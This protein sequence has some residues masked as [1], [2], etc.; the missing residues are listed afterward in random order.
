[1]VEVTYHCPYCGAVTGIEREGYLADR[2][3]TKEPLDGWTY[4]DTT[5]DYEDAD[6][7]ELICIGDA[8][9]DEGC[10][11]TFYLSFVRYRAGREV[12]PEVPL[13]DYEDRPRFDFL[14]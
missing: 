1:M 12:D 13:E 11:R 8:G 4:A 7:V 3:V 14:S 6:G 9:D 10:G 2:C 5:D